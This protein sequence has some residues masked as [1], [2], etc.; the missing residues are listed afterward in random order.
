MYLH[1]SHVCLVPA[2]AKSVA[3]PGTGV[4]NGGELLCEFWELNPGPLQEQQMLLTIEYLQP[5]K[6]S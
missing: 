5:L 3:F 4:I 1:A 6:R 2:K